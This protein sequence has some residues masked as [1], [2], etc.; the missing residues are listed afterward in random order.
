MGSETDI[1]R[2]LQRHLDTMPVGFPKTKSGV[3]IRLLEAV[4]T[5]EQA[6][7]A[8]HLHH[9]HQTVDQIYES[10]KEEVSSKEELRRILDETVSR[11]GIFRRRRDGAEQYA[12]M[13]FVAYSFAKSNM[14]YHME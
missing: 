6:R 11:G 5:P 13:P 2:R 4:F 1:Y 7:V 3:E 12:V 14:L 9:K 8:A 10:A